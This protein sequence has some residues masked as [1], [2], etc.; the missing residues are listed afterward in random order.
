M[1]PIRDE[2]FDRMDELTPAEKKVARS[3]LANYPSAGLA[4]AA[5]LA[6]TAGTSTPTVLRLVARIGIGSYPEFQERLR[7]EVT[8]RLNSPVSRAADRLSADGD[9]TLFT[10]SVTQRLGLVE[11]LTTTVPPSEFD[12]AVALLAGPARSIVV[13]GGYFSRFVG[14]VLALQLDQLVPGVELAHEPLGADIGRYLSMGR[15]SVAVIFDLRRHELPAKRLAALAKQQGAS[16]LVITD[17]ELSPAADD[18]DVVLPVPV[19]GVPFDSFAALVVLVEALVEGVFQK[20][21]TA[22]LDRMRQW[23]ESVVI[24]RAFRAGPEPDDEDDEDEED[25]DE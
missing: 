24:H 6:R 18:A 21:G 12:A 3:L 5:T 23:E 11:R 2:V 4:S 20:V 9:G 16:V 19:D 13:S 25:R 22:G 1:T 15:D 8:Q 7:E 14:Q 10:R 17:E